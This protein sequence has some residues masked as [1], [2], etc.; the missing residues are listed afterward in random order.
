M[1]LGPVD[2]RRGVI[3]LRPNNIRIVGGE[4]EDLYESNRMEKVLADTL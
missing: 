2:C 3:H 1:V 4:V